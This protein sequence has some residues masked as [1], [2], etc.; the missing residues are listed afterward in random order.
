MIQSN[1]SLKTHIWKNTVPNWFPALFIRGKQIGFGP[2]VANSSFVLSL[3]WTLFVS[4]FP[5][6]QICVKNHTLISAPLTFVGAWC[7]TECR[8]TGALSGSDVRLR[9]QPKTGRQSLGAAPVLGLLIL[10]ANAFVSQ[11]QCEA[12]RLSFVLADFSCCLGALYFWC[13]GSIMN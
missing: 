2:L 6:K 4:I 3:H 11:G 12:F 5:D 9:K 10:S 13:L 7:P 1:F 8:A